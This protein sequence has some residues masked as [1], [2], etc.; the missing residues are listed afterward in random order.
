MKNKFFLVLV[1]G[2]V[3]VIGFALSWAS[4][5]N[6]AGY[7]EIA[8]YISHIDFKKHLLT[9]AFAPLN[10]LF[11]IGFEQILGISLGNAWKLTDLLFGG[12]ITA[13]LSTVYIHSNSK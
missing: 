10:Y 9:S 4:I 13:F 8:W 3:I 11:V 1:C 6:L 12:L 7:T 2:A 5:P